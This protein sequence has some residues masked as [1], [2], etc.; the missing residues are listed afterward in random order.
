MI[1]DIVYLLCALT[2]VLCAILLFRGWRTSRA[3]LLFWGAVC[4]AGLALNN[5][6]LVIDMRMD[7]VD[8]AGIRLLPALA[9]VALL[10]YGLIRNE[11]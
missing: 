5:I 3:R 8:L 9:G 1:A 7:Q 2:S 4:F 6:L 10:I 11:S